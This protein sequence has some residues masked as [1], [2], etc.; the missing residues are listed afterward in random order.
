MNIP[1][2]WIIAVGSCLVGF[3]WL[4]GT[5]AQL[6]APPEYL[7]IGGAALGALVAANKW[8]NLKNIILAT[9]RVFVR[10][11]TSKA[12]NVQLLSLMFELL[13]KIKRDG[14]LSIDSDI[15]NPFQSA[16]FGK[17][18]RVLKHRRLVEFITD[19]FRMMVD[20]TV[21]LSQ[22]ETVMAQE[23]DV[24]DM[25]A[26]EPSQSLSGLADSLPAFGIVAAITGVIHTLSTLTEGKTPAEIGLGIASALIG[27]LFGVFASYAVFGPVANT[28]RQLADSEL[29]P[30]QA[31]KE[32][33]IANYSNF[34]PIVAVEYGRKV[35][36][37]DQR[38]SAAE[39]EAGV[40]SASGQPMRGR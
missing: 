18:P 24:M 19:Y 2:G 27:T 30:F 31:V 9:G 38:P 13:Q 25:E 8:R 10:S 1:V 11:S 23:I 39:L 3:L 16:L 22:L 34:S 28:L 36:F 14:A 32:I 21:T 6:W 20:G 5:S 17:Y 15:Q 12:D 33:L 35:L 40:M 37:S 4:G 29:R 7:I 26:R